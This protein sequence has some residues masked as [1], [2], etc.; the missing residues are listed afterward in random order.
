MSYTNE[1]L[2]ISPAGLALIKKWEGWYPKAYKDPVGVWTIGWGTT[3]TEAR[4]GRTITKK[5]GEE[6]LRNDLKNDEET[7]KSLVKV[8]LSQYEFDALV[9]F[10]YNAGGG[11]LKQST[12]LKLLNRG[13]KQ[14]A[15]A[16]FIRWNK[17]RNRETNEWVTLD[18]LTN[19]RKD[20]AALFLRSPSDAFKSEDL[21][22]ESQKPLENP[23]SHESTVSTEAPTEH[24][25]PWTEVFKNT[26][27]FK[28]VASA[29]TGVFVA[30]TQLLEPIK[31][32]PIAVG[33]FGV[34][35]VGL[36][37]VVFIKKR[38][39]QEGR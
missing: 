32:N 1:N 29:L 34:A 20:E 2:T 31:D 5:Q 3:G 10:V 16:Q 13:N 30:L 17:A 37:Y 19:R 25:T 4:P 6:F 7:V 9:S 22:M 38:D 14:A 18:G 33:G 39:T 12:L 35:V 23:Q 28:G 24:P 36:V 11:N 8:P 26:D 27:T 15:A 21:D